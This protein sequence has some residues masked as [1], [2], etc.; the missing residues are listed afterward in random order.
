MKQFIFKYEQKNN[1]GFTIIE[2]MIYMFIMSFLIFI[3]NDIMIAALERK[4][5]FES[6]SNVEMDSRY[7]IKRLEYDINRA[8][9]ISTPTAVGLTASS[10]VISIG[11]TQNTYSISSGNMVLTNQ[12]GNNNLNSG[13]TS[14]SNVY[15]ARYGTST[16]KSTIRINFTMQ[17]LIKDKQGNEIRTVNTTVGLR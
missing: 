8:S 9:T 5:D 3:I 17:S 6:N 12:D 16:G 11:G 14:L 1:L 7:I 15:F 13:Y 10:L 4:A 2:L